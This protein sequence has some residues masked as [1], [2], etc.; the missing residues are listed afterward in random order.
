[1]KEVNITEKINKMLQVCV[2]NFD[3]FNRSDTEAPSIWNGYA[4]DMVLNPSL[5]VMSPITCGG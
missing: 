2:D 5:Y 4:D 1:M 3:V